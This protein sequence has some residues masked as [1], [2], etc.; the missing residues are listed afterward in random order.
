VIYNVHRPS[1]KIL[2]TLCVLI[3]IAAPHLSHAQ[4][5]GATLS[6]TVTDAIGG[7]LQSATINVKNEATGTAKS[8]EVDPQGHFSLSGLAPGRYSV[9]VSAPGFSANRR[10]VQ[11]NTGQNMDHHHSAE[12][13]RCLPAGNC[14]GERRGLRRRRAC[15]HGRFA[16][17]SL[18]V[19]VRVRGNSK[20]F[21]VVLKDG[22]FVLRALP[23]ATTLAG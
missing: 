10:A 7:V 11:L 9:E 21:Y 20:P 15:A 6:G 22:A 14:R 8:V 12:H 18:E 17:C 19:A 3:F 16:R 4:Q 5:A 23:K 13:Q 1:I 2:L